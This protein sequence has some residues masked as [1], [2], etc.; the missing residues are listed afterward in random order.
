MS[1]TPARKAVH[2]DSQ[3]I[4]L[5]GISGKKHHGKNTVADA[6]R[7]LVYDS[8]VFRAAFP[9]SYAFMYAFADA[10]KDE[11][12]DFLMKQ[13]WGG[14]LGLTHSELTLEARESD[15]WKTLDG[16]VFDSYERIPMT[17]QMAR[18]TI[19]GWLEGAA[20]PEK[21][22]QYRLLMQWWG[23]EYRRKMFGDDYWVQQ[24]HKTVSAWE[25]GPNDSSKI[26]VL[27]PDVRF[28]NEA[29]YIQDSGGYLIRVL[30]PDLPPAADPHPSETALDVWPHF[31]QVIVNNSRSECEEQARLL[32]PAILDWK[33]G[34]PS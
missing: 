29:R 33:W 21:K 15:Y 2:L 26:I 4:L 12:T 6:M 19:R 1:E 14:T 32:L 13:L 27:V 28:E 17:E 25:P 30:R 31:D 5:V 34:S 7:E 22:E 9:S 16:K 24:L 20:G 18:Q 10:L 8:E 11:V 23:T 3:K